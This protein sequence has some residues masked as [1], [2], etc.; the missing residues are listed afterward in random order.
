[1]A[2]RSFLSWPFLDDTHR[3]LAARLD[4]WVDQELAPL[5]GE[6]P[7][8][9]ALDETMK[10]KDAE[11]RCGLMVIDLASGDI[12]HWLRIE[13]IVTEL[14]DVIALP[15]VTRPM[16]LGFKTDEIQRM[17]SVGDQGTL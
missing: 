5:T 4:T 12:V 7:T 13:G 17:V 14:Y 16:A 11:A 8:G 10:E 2:D 15:G 9:L 6:E 1:M 3:A